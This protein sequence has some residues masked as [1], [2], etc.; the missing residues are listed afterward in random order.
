MK[1]LIKEKLV[2]YL[3]KSGVD[4]Y[5]QI[6]VMDVWSVFGDMT[7]EITEFS[8][9]N[10]NLLSISTYGGSLGT[11]TGFNVHDIKDADIRKACYDASR[12]NE[13]YKIAMTQY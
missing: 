10:N 11:Y 4:R 1:E 5:G 13:T 12:E 7:E 3:E 8:K 2:S 9:N 6:K